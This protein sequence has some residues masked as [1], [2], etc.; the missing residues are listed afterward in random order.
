MKEC[1]DCALN[2]NDVYSE[3][4]VIDNNSTDGT[5]E[6]LDS[7][8][9]KRI[10]CI[11]EN[12]NIGGAGG[13]HDGVKYAYESTNCDWI[14]LIDDD[15]MIDRNYL[16]NIKSNM[17]DH[18]LAYAGAVYV[19]GEIDARHRSRKNIG[20]VSVAEYESNSFICNVATFCGL[21]I[22]KKI[23]AEIGF[24]RKDF[25][26]WEDDT[27]YCYRFMKLTRILVVTN[28]VLN[29][30]TVNPNYKIGNTIKDDWKLYYGFRNQLVIYRMY[31]KKKYY[32]KKA[33]LYGRAIQFRLKSLVNKNDALDLLYNASLRIDAVRDSQSHRMGRNLKY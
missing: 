29:H 32:I 24:P 26:I 20:A 14:L 17:D 7:L 3:L 19:N 16:S 18:Y 11:H 4:V 12:E 23:V 2:Q 30:K 25:F 5:G 21:L 27:E 1:I 8:N 28:A 6:Y 15:A 22:S 33:K 10:H 31:D 13:F 9:N